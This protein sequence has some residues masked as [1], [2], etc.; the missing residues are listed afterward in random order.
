MNIDRRVQGVLALM[1]LL[2][3]WQALY[4]VPWLHPAVIPSPYTILIAFENGLVTGE[5]I[6]HS[7]ASLGR[8]LLGFCAAAVLGVGLGLSLARFGFLR[9]LAEPLIELLKPIPP[10]AWIPIA[11]LLFGLGDLPSYFIVFIGAFFPIYLNTSFGALQLPTRYI[12]LARTLELSEYTYFKDVLFKFALPYIFTGFRI[13]IGMAW[14][15]VIA[16]ELIG[17]QS[18]LGYYIQMNRLMLN[19]D[20]VIAGM[21]AIG[22]LGFLLTAGIRRIEAHCVPWKRD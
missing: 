22:V 7:L 2:A 8:I 20:R 13:G 9:P 5:I 6:G 14:M 19:T 21:M 1:L 3:A 11:I 18:G 10:I 4:L 17:A 12:N 15:S 16:A